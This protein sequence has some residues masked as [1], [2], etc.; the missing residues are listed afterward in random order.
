MSMLRFS[1]RSGRRATPVNT[2]L[3]AQR[4]ASTTTVAAVTDPSYGVTRQTQP[5]PAP[6]A[7][8]IRKEATDVR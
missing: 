2:R 5:V 3:V 4:S 7:P 1:R 8:A 6:H